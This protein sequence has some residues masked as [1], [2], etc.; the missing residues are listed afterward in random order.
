MKQHFFGRLAMLFVLSASLL[1]VL[2]YNV[3]YWGVED[4]DNI[5]DAHDAYYHYKFIETWGDFS[6]TTKIKEELENLKI[7]AAIYSI[8]ADTICTED[9]G[10]DQNLEK[11]LTYWSNTSKQFSLCDYISYQG[12]ER[13]SDVHNITFPGYVSFGDIWVGEQLYPATVIEKDQYQIL[14]IITN[15]VYPN[16]WVTF[17][18]VVFLL[19]IFMFL[20]YRLLR[21]FLRPITLM[22][23]R[24]FAL[25]AGDLDSKIEIIGQDELALLSKNFN[26]LIAEIKKLLKQKE[27]LLADVSHELRTPLAKIRLLAEIDTPSEKMDRINKQI[28]TLDSIITNILISDK[29]AAPYSNLNLEKITIENLLQQGL[30]LSKNKNV[31][32]VTKTPLQVYCDVVKI[33]IVIK[34]LLDNAE[35]YAPSDSPVDI[36]YTKN[37]NIVQINVIDRGP[38][39]PDSLIHKMMEPYVRGENL[40]KSG[41]GLGLSICKRIMGAHNGTIKAINNQTKGATFSIGWDNKKINNINN[42]KK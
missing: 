3:I 34:N 41:F 20:L 18:P 38:G 6:D 31:K 19:F 23:T 24:I 39:I 36:T 26:T 4:K 9:Y 13:L 22:Q 33:A 21:H 5:L 30:D 14:L 2:T 42:A 28:D 17:A 37:K 16:E 11:S 15:Y 1:V 10:W 40:Q 8:N 32:V 12:S 29:L 27:R 25:E 35:K 7:T